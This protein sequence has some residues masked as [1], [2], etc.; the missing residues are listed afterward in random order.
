MKRCSICHVIKALTEFY[1]RTRSKD[2]RRGECKLCGAASVL[3]WQ[4]ENPVLAN[5]KS[6][7]WQRFNR[8]SGR[9]SCARY[10]KRH[11]EK[12]N[13]LHAQWRK[14]NRHIVNQWSARYKA[15]KR[16]AIP[17]WA[18]IT[19]MNEWYALARIKSMLTRRSWVVDHIVPLR[20]PM[21]C[22]LHTD[23]NMQVILNRDNLVKGNRFW[24][25]MP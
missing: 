12:V 5:A 18:N 1:P 23:Y 19:A 14:K 11:A 2:G 10:A 4:K 3:L 24:P 21:V 15:S 13:L 20:S 6:V 25:D 9:R 8:G 22:G 17:G 16:H 7:R